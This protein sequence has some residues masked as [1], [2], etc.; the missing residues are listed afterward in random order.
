VSA[1]SGGKPRGGRGGARPGAGRPRL[2]LAQLVAERRF[3][4]RSPRHRRALLEDELPEMPATMVELAE[5]YRRTAGTQGAAA[6]SW[7]AQRF[8][9]LAADP[10]WEA[11]VEASNERLR[12]QARERRERLARGR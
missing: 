10:D 7:L 2:R 1:D 8:A 12:V 3:D 4:W 5:A 11:W 6:A 9:H